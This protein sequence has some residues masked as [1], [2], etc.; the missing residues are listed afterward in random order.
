[1]KKLF[2]WS[3]LSTYEEEFEDQ[4][5]MMGFVPEKAV[6]D[7]LWF[8]PQHWCKAYFDTICKNS[9]CVNNFTE[10]FNKWIL[11]S[12]ARP[13]IK[14]LEDIRIKVLLLTIS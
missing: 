5:N 10:S 11:K 4:L 7:L 14:I 3:A 12:R 6:K 9:T 13:I 2:W 8:P 1:M